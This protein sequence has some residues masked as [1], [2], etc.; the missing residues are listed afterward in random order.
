MFKNRKTTINKTALTFTMVFSFVCMGSYMLDLLTL[1][2]EPIFY[3]RAINIFIASTLLLCLSITGI[4]SKNSLIRR[5]PDVVVLEGEL[6]KDDELFYYTNK[7]RVI[8]SVSYLLVVVRVFVTI[9]MVIL[10]IALVLNKIQ[11]DAFAVACSTMVITIYLS[12]RVRKNI[13]RNKVLEDGESYVSKGYLQQSL[14]MFKMALMLITVVLLNQVGY[15]FVKIDDMVINYGVNAL[16]LGVVLVAIDFEPRRFLTKIKKKERL[17]YVV[18]RVVF[19]FSHVIMLF[20]LTHMLKITRAKDLVA[21][22]LIISMVLV[23]ISLFMV[24]DYYKNS[25]KTL[26]K[27]LYQ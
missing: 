24:Y 27:N 8:D 2:L 18:S 14:G 1:N 19:A 13:Y 7:E 15:V 9:A 26:N 17:K 5:K 21:S 3:E 10:F 25:L 20:A 22:E 11:L 16:L 4:Y 23:L 6:D 12:E